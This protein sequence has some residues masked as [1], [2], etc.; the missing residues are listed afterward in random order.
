MTKYT[1]ALT[2]RPFSIGT[3]P[4]K[5]TFLD[6]VDY[7]EREHVPGIGDIWGY[8]FYSEPLTDEEIAEYELVRVE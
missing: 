5:S 3:Y 8:L 2:Q 7:D 6:H 4:K 1:Y